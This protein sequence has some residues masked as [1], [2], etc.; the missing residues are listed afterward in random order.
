MR[1]VPDA[2][3]PRVVIE[4]HGC[5]LNGADSQRIARELIATGYTIAAAG[6]RPDV[7]VLNT[8]TVTHVADRKARQAISSARRRWPAALLVATGCYAERDPETVAAL[9]G[10]DLVVTARQ[11]EQIV[12]RITERLDSSLSPCGDGAPKESLGHLLGRTRAFLKIQEGCNQ[13]CAYCIVPTVRGR[14]RSVPDDILV[15]QVL[16]L[17]DE[18]CQEVV[19][20]GTQLGSYGFDLPHTNL[21]R[22]LRR[23][24]D[25]TEIVRLRVSSLQPPELVPELLA[26]WTGV[27]RGRL[28]PHFHI[29]LQSGSDKVLRRMRRRYTSEQ[30]DESVR[31]VRVAV[32]GA[33]ITTDVIAGFPGEMDVDFRATLD[34]AREVR[35]AA[36]HVFP[37]SSRPGTSADHFDGHVP[38]TVRAGRAARLREVAAA[39]A[40]EFRET[41]VGS[42]RT[43]LWE[44]SRP[45]RGL[46]DNYI[47]VEMADENHS[48]LD[49]INVI[50]EVELTG[51]SGETMT[52]RPA[53]SSS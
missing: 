19:L 20:T 9:A 7:Y 48:E 43:V 16:R 5:K 30:L 35:F 18:G 12:R 52:A 8:C 34:I 27:G 6:E 15:E 29:P 47:R 11:Q 32:P 51:V 3:T 36:M 33:A 50:E 22:M 10:V 1:E 13:V 23:I 17:V 40:G 42:V 49:R 25:E 31:Q 24:L 2:A 41:L 4:T 44:Q 14:E 38:A 39:Y 37:Y 53:K 28:C 26:L 21:A 45:M 46:T